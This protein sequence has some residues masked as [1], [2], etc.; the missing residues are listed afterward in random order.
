MIS[1]A[2]NATQ[3]IKIYAT[4]NLNDVIRFVVTSQG[5]GERLN[6]CIEYKDRHVLTT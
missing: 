5:P 4:K 6:Q 2:L 1:Q 3:N